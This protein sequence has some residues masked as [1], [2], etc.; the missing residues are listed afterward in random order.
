MAIVGIDFFCGAGGA[1][2]GFQN[3]GIQILKGMDNDPTCKE[4]YEKNCFPSKFLL[5]DINELEPE[6]VLDGIHLSKED[7]LFF[8]ACAPC[9]PFSKFAK[10]PADDDRACLI[11]T[12]AE[13]VRKLIPDIVFIENVPG[14]AKAA[15]GQILEQLL[16]IL[17]SS[18]L[19][20][21]YEWR[22]VDA[23]S[24]GVQQKR[25][26]FIMLA[27]RI[28]EI[29]FPPKTHG[30][31]L[32]PY[33]T[34]RHTISKYPPIRAGETHKD[35]PNHAAAALSELNIK[36]ISKTPKDGGS[37]KDWP[38]NL[39]LECHK[40]SLGHTDVYGRMSWDNPSP[41]LTCRCNSISNGRFGH[42]E[43][44]RAISLREAAALQTFPDDFIFYGKN[45]NIA[46]HVGNA[47]PPLI[48]EVFGK[49]IF[50]FVNSKRKKLERVME[51]DLI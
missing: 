4:T 20:Y 7:H 45:T 30:K 49:S 51:C 50:N 11:L 3:T 32:L 23:K 25:L 48:A 27:S 19:G 47:V 46:R 39:W 22:L 42:P 44:D 29:P 13:F 14:L 31:N 34:V 36:R 21:K 10:G 33:V 15:Q 18:G 24:Y 38:R 26:R 2:K 5:K 43:Q 16:Q 37:R 41:T 35:V 40:N 9:Q 17:E 8:I 12:F 1:T 6:G 28:G